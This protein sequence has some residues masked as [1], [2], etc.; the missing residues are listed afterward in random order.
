M[1]VKKLPGQE[2][3]PEAKEKSKDYQDKPKVQDYYKQ[4]AT[5]DGETFPVEKVKLTDS[6]WLVVETEQWVGFVHGNS[7]LAKHV[8]NVIAPMAHNK[9]GNQL[10]AIAAKKHKNKF[11]LGLEDEVKMW[12][13]FDQERKFLE[14]SIEKEEAFLVPEGL[15]KLE[16]FGFTE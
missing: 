6:G 4:N 12:Y 9:Q 10:V 16:D 7:E 13:Y 15:L 8:M 14:L 1:A 3:K 11:V 2:P 5:K